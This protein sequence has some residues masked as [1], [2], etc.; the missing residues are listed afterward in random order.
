MADLYK[1]FGVDWQ[2]WS[3]NQD[4]ELFEEQLRGWR[5]RVHVDVGVQLAHQVQERLVET[6]EKVEN[7]SYRMKGM[8]FNNSE[9]VAYWKFYF[10]NLC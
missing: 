4:F 2:W 6:A 7:I 3:R 9:K 8:A 1:P 10:S 5:E